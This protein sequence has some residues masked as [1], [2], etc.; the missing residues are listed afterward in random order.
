M[1]NEVDPFL[2]EKRF[3]ADDWLSASAPKG[4]AH[5]SDAPPIH[6]QITTTSQAGGSAH[7]PRRRCAEPSLASAL[8]DTDRLE[9]IMATMRPFGN[10]TAATGPNNLNSHFAS[11]DASSVPVPARADAA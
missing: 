2:V 1:T 3:R 4:V 6:R 11:K 10:C 5:C 7:S 9:A 8:V